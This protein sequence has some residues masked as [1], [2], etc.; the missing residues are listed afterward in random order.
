M[1]I[2]VFSRPLMKLYCITR[3]VLTS[4]TQASYISHTPTITFG[5]GVDCFMHL[6]Y[7]MDDAACLNIVCVV[8]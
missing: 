3:Y 8:C 2:H 5:G 7:V 6:A 1:T 4:L